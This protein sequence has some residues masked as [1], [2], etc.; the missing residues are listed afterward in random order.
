MIEQLTPPSFEQSGLQP[1]LSQPEVF[2]LPNAEVFSPRN[3]LV[4]SP[5]VAEVFGPNKP[6]NYDYLF[7]DEDLVG[8]VEDAAVRGPNGRG[9][10]TDISKEYSIDILKRFEAEEGLDSK[11][12]EIIHRHNKNQPLVST[13]TMDIIRNDKYLRMELGVYFLSKLDSMKDLLP[14]RVAENTQKNST[15]PGYNHIPNLRSREYASLLALAHLDGTF[16]PE[17]SLSEQPTYNDRGLVET[18]QHRVAS[19]MLLFW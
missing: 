7:G 1:P 14:K 3:E 10:V 18:G 12:K 19:E 8:S 15:M 9:V 13:T 17:K 16:D 11:I 4:F 6:D 2:G 5:Y